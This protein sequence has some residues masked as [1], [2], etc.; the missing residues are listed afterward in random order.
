MDVTDEDRLEKLENVMAE[1]DS[2]PDPNDSVNRVERTVYVPR[3]FSYKKLFAK[4]NFNKKDFYEAIQPVTDHYRGIT[5]S[6]HPHRPTPPLLDISKRWETDPIDSTDEP[7]YD[8][9]TFLKHVDAVDDLFTLLYSFKGVLDRYPKN[10]DYSTPGLKTTFELLWGEVWAYYVTIPRVTFSWVYWDILHCIKEATGKDWTGYIEGREG[11]VPPIDVTGLPFAEEE[12]IGSGSTTVVPGKFEGGGLPVGSQEDGGSSGFRDREE[13]DNDMGLKEVEPFTF[14]ET[15]AFQ[16]AIEEGLGNPSLVIP[17]RKKTIPIGMP[18]DREKRLREL[19]EKVEQ[20]LPELDL[21]KEWSDA[22]QEY[23]YK[24]TQHDHPLKENI[25]FLFT[26][27]VGIPAIMKTQL[28]QELYISYY[29]QALIAIN[30]LGFYE[31]VQGFKDLQ[32]AAS[33]LRSGGN[34]KRGPYAIPAIYFLFKDNDYEKDKSF[35]KTQREARA[36]YVFI[37]TDFPAYVK[38]LIDVDIV[39]IE[40]SWKVFKGVYKHFKSDK[41]RADMISKIE[42]ADPNLIIRELIYVIEGPPLP[43]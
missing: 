21:V 23:T 6:D 11:E 33:E 32:P 2:L 24:G 16:K 15:L 35:F 20:P 13:N 1:I 14:E 5:D 22:L 40:D 31:Y 42:K 8:S 37:L 36:A 25:L 19:I 43:P 27:K 9:A 18:F 28:N 29:Y 41:V 34:K 38:L 26:E 4:V 10:S 7:G 39:K 3:G 30:H 12:S 17:P